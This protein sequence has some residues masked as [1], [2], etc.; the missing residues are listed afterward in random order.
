L[1][2]AINQCVNA[3]A[4]RAEAGFEQVALVGELLHLA[5]QQGI[6]ALQFFVA[7]QQMLDALGNLIDQ[8]C[9]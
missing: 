3:V 2:Q 1:G 6:G 4:G 5:G 7:Q 8:G 9:L